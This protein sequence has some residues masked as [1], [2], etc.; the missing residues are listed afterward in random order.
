SAQGALDGMQASAALALAGEA[1]LAP[2]IAEL[3]AGL[4][5]ED[6]QARLGELYPQMDETQLA[7]IMARALF[8][9][10]VWG[11]VQA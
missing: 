7:E 3:D 1:L 8:V 6:M 5:P 4:S 2:L 10:E 11:R 9:S